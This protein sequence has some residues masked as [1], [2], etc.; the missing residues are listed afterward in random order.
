MVLNKK[1]REVGQEVRK[2]RFWKGKE[3]GMWYLVL[4]Q[5]EAKA[6]TEK[7]RKFGLLEDTFFF[8][9]YRKV[10]RRVIK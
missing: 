1:R 3:K 5:I 2:M 4:D 7:I 9:M 8:E 6:L 10:R